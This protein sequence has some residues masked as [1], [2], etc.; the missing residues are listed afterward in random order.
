[1]SA[2][3]N[4]HFYRMLINENCRVTTADDSFV[5]VCKDLSSA[6]MAFEVY[7]KPLPIGTKINIDID[8]QNREFPSFSAEADVIREPLR[9]GN[10]FVIGVK[11]TKMN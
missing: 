4:R 11:F 8:S 9:H 5:A 2:V 7:D 1:M 3:D 10:H 6:G